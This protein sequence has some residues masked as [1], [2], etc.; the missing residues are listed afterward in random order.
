MPS[1]HEARE[2]HV[3]WFI[4]KNKR[5]CLAADAGLVHLL[6][7]WTTACDPHALGGDQR[8]EQR[9][10][11]LDHS[12]TARKAQ[13]VFGRDPQQRRTWRGL[14]NRVPLR[15]PMRSCQQVTQQVA[16]GVEE[17]FSHSKEVA[18]RAAFAAEWQ[19][20]HAPCCSWGRSQRTL[21]KEVSEVKTSLTC[22]GKRTE[23]S[24]GRK[25]TTRRRALEA[26]CE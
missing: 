15:R 1:K 6:W 23:S 5:R 25:G 22:N 2:R 13:G 26:M 7:G 8:G 3:E 14:G 21:T 9:G 12:T 17:T 16:P 10:P 19:D 20:A 4:T 24:G 18:L 11:Y